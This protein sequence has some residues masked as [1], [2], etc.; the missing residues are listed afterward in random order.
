MGGGGG[1]WVRALP[2]IGNMYTGKL[3]LKGVPF[4]DFRYMI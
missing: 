3:C 4:S 1:G 2:I